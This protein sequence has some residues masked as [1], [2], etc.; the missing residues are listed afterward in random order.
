MVISIENQHNQGSNLEQGCLY[1]NYNTLGKG[2]NLIILSP[3]IDKQHSLPYS[4]TLVGQ[5]VYQSSKVTRRKTEFKPVKC[6][7]IDLEL[8]FVHGGGVG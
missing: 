8:H 7:K 4:L 2:M 1:F 3:A 6:L 5:P